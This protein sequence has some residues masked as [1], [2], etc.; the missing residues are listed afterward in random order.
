MT[1]LGKDSY[2]GTLH[3]KALDPPIV[4]GVDNL[5]QTCDIGNTT[6]TPIICD[7][8]SATTGDI[9]TS[10]G[11]ITSSVNITASTGAVITNTITPV[12]GTIVDFSRTYRGD[13]EVQSLTIPGP[14][15]FAYCR[16]DIVSIRS[17]TAGG[18]WV[19]PTG[20]P[21][22][23]FYFVNS[24]GNAQRLQGPLTGTL[25][26][27]APPNFINLAGVAPAPFVIK[28]VC[29]RAGIWYSSNV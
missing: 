19:L 26:T 20:E 14:I 24:S 28:L 17:G 7:S 5:Q 4:I 22:N 9:T 8:L 18:V 16:G 13:L 25:D 10:T 21:G 2:V 15:D 1:S 23:H 27:L 29:I 3:Y 11:S 12:S 6:T